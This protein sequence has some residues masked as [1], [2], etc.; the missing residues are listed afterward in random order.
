MAFARGTAL[1]GFTRGV[2][3]EGH[4]GRA[5]GAPL[6]VGSD[7]YAGGLNDVPGVFRVR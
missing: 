4:A 6:L 3:L 7:D 1:P 5:P 2:A